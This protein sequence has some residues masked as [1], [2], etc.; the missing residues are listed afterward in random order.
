MAYAPSR[1]RLNCAKNEEEDDEEEDEKDDGGGGDD[2]SRT[3]I[4]LC[5]TSSPFPTS[6]LHLGVISKGEKEGDE[7]EGRIEWHLL[8]SLTFY[9]TLV[10][11]SPLAPANRTSVAKTRPWKGVTCA[12]AAAILA[13]LNYE[14]C[15]ARRRASC[16]LYFE[17]LIVA[18][19][20]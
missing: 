14:P 9:Y 15:A 2:V 11:L 16:V 18:A 12:T 10:L 19:T 7:M 13:T 4:I 6:S 8:P 20:L 5:L 17:S 1:S 3:E